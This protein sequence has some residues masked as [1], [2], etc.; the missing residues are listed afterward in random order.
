MPAWFGLAAVPV[1]ILLNAF[2]VAG[3]YAVVA[4]RGTHLAGLRARGHRRAADAMERLKADPASAIG[5][6]QVCITM[7]NL[8]LGWIGEPAVGAVLARALG[9]LAGVLPGPVFRGT[10]FVLSFVAVTFLTVVLSELLP[11]ALTLRYVPAVVALTAVPVTFVLAGTKP[12]VWL[13]NAT[14]NAITRPLG[15]GTVQ[16]AERE[17]HT[18]EEIRSIVSE[19]ARHGELSPRERS[20]VLNSLALGRRTARQVLV[21]RVRVQHLDLT[22]PLARNRAV[23]DAYLHEYFPL[24][25]GGLD[26]VTG[27]VSAREFLTAYFAEPEL[28]SAGDSTVLQLI[29]RPAVF[30]PDTVSLDRL[31]VVFDERRT[32]MLMLVDEHGGLEGICTLNDVVDELVGDPRVPASRDAEPT[33]PESLAPAAAGDPQASAPPTQPFDVDGALPLHELAARLGDPRSWADEAV[34]TVAGLVAKRLGRIPV[35]GDVVREPRAEL[36]V[37]ES[38]GRAAQRVRVTPLSRPPPAADR[39]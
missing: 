18:A 10:S 39:P 15:L 6:I 14:A 9:P 36:R 24:C 31:L 13:M 22:W 17:W 35:T 26:K 38:D 7:T 16:G 30:A 34:V 5:A 12:L 2:F 33:T 25:N 11:K 23:I 4:A 19:A 21:P 37:L 3:E 27:I 29:A 28:G 8:L 1:L 20:L 32:Q